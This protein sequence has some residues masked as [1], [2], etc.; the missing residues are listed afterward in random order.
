MT[1]CSSCE[2]KTSKNGKLFQSWITLRTACSWTR[3]S[4]SSII[5]VLVS[6]KGTPA[7]G[8]IPTAKGITIIVLGAISQAGIIDVSL[9][10]PQAVSVSKKRQFNHTTATVIT[11]R[12]GTRTEHFL[13]YMA[14]VMDVLDRNGMKGNYLV[15]I[16]FLFI[17]LPRCVIIESR[18]YKCFSYRHT[19]LSLTRLRTLVKIKAGLRR[20]SLSCA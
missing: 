19:R 13:S 15:M 14:N 4:S 2:G 11:G 10:K 1:V 8:I 18:G 16:V 3:Q 5:N 12:V 20:N 7:K 6:R 9:K 17:H